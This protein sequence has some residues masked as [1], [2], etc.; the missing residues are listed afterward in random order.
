VKVKMNT[1]RDSPEALIMREMNR[2]IFAQRIKTPK[3][4]FTWM[5]AVDLEIQLDKRLHEQSLFENLSKITEEDVR[6]RLTE[7]TVGKRP[8]EPRVAAFLEG[9]FCGRSYRVRISK[10]DRSRKD[11]TVRVLYSLLDE[12]YVLRVQYDGPPIYQ[13]DYNLKKEFGERAIMHDDSN[14]SSIFFW[15]EFDREFNWKSIFGSYVRDK[16]RMEL[17]T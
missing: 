1:A 6:R 5:Y 10:P 11:A 7:M 15:V 13:R 16:F 17:L 2:Q 9:I 3:G 12:R 14:K 4:M 8:Q